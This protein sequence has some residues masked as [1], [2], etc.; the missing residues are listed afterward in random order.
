MTAAGP[1]I[2]IVALARRFGGADRRVIGLARSLRGRRDCR[3]AVLSGSPLHRALAAENLP[4]CPIPS[5]RGNP[6]AA[7]HLYRIIRRYRIGVVDLHNPQSQLWGTVAALIA[8]VPERVVTVHSRYRESETGILRPRAYEVVLRLC[9]ATGARVMAVSRT[10]ADYAR[11]LGM[12]AEHIHLSENGLPPAAPADG[13]VWRAALGIPPAVPLIVAVGR[14]TPVKGFDVLI[15]AI[16]A[17]DRSADAL[18]VA[19]AGDGP[20]RDRLQA[21][22]DHHGLADR[23]R[24]LGFVDDVD[25]LLAAADLFCMPS[26]TE[27]LPYAALEAA[28]RRVPVVAAAIDAIS[29]IFEDGRTATLVAPECPE[30]L[31]AGLRRALDRPDEMAAR[32]ERAGTMIDRRFSLAAMAE[33][34]LAVYDRCAPPVIR[35]DAIEPAS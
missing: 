7:W 31:A 33:S 26:R 27:G 3:V 23:V 32:A 6:L 16:A 9:R 4:A 34:T 35:A 5:G 19:I 8:G 13:T 22:I 14:L 20:E 12:A 11:G 18:R 28:Q 15:R 1:P 24:L 10:V 21:R 29:A 2:L 30:A 17:M 25:G